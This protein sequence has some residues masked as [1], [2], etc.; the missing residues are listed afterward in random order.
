LDQRAVE[1]LVDEDG[2]GR[3]GAGDVDG[4][5]DGAERRANDGGATDLPRVAPLTTGLGR[6][7]ARD[8]RGLGRSADQTDEDK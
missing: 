8:T 7:L 4:G 2:V 6:G 5:R 1:V 3:L